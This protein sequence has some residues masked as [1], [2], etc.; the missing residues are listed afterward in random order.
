MKTFIDTEKVLKEIEAR[1]YSLAK[2][3]E[4][5]ASKI[6]SDAFLWIAGGSMVASMLYKSYRKDETANFV[7]QWVPTI[8]ILGLYSKLAKVPSSELTR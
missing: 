3:I 7:G 6:P 8:L 4:E 5:Q 1:E 2:R